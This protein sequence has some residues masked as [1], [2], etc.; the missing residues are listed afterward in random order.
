[1]RIGVFGGSFDP[2]HKTHLNIVQ[3]VLL[4]DLVDHVIVIPSYIREDKT[5]VICPEHRLNMCKLC[6][7][8][9]RDV[10]V[11]SL[12]IDNKLNG[13]SLATFEFI[14]KDERINSFVESR[15]KNQY[16][17]I[18]VADCIKNIKTWWNWEKLIETIPFIV[19]QRPTYSFLN[20]EEIEIANMFKTSH[21]QTV[22]SNI[23]YDHI[24]STTIR[25]NIIHKPEYAKNM[26]TDKVWNY[27]I[28]HQLYGAKL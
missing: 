25:H 2:P 21:H 14:L 12:E 8:H 6:F 16:Y 5:N 17:N 7:G 15:D 20:E 11:S 18:V 22:Q 24:S 27:I 4:Q 19:Y 28:N 26:V 9:I 23:I 1:M 3:D 10:I 13:K